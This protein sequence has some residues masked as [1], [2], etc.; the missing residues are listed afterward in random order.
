MEGTNA[1]LVRVIK[2]EHSD[3]IFTMRY[4]FI[5]LEQ[6]LWAITYNM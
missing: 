1:I 4:H 3:V 5:L 2:S 6:S